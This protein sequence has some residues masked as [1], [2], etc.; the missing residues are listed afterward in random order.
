MPTEKRHFPLGRGARRAGWVFGSIA[1]AFL[2]CSR[3]CTDCAPTPTGAEF[4]P[5]KIGTFVEYEVQEQ[6]FALG[7][8]PV[9]RSYQLKELMAEKY[10]N[11]AGQAAYRIVRFYRQSAAQS[12]QPDSTITLRITANGQAIRNE[13]GRDFLKM[14]LPVYEKATWNGN[15]YN[16]LGQDQYEASRVGKPF[17]VNGQTFERTATVV[18]Q[19]DSTLVGQDKRLEIYAADVGLIYRENNNVQFCS[20]L[21]ACV[22]KAQIDFGKR[23]YVRFKKMGLE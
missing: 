8:P 1:A 20:S 2:S 21:P 13:N 9:E 5:L 19:N 18:Q 23:Q 4:F 11:V 15:A 14:T 16:A 17:K 3:P 12:W 6:E 22:G 10:Q 7:R